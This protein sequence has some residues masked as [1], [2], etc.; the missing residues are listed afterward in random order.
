[1]P[2]ITQKFKKG[3][4]IKSFITVDQENSSGDKSEE[5]DFEENSE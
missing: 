4:E 5:E 3:K 1:M 2:R